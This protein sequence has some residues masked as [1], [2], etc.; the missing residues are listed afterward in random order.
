MPA[1]TPW[2]S[3]YSSTP[4]GF[5][6]T[7]PA[8]IALEMRHPRRVVTATLNGRREKILVLDKLL[9]LGPRTSDADLVEFHLMRV[10]LRDLPGW[11][12]TLPKGMPRPSDFNL[13]DA[14]LESVK[15][16][17]GP[18]RRLEFHLTFRNAPYRVALADLPA[19]LLKC[20]A[21]TV[22][23]A[24]GKKLVDIREMRLI[25]CE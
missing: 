7:N 2:S 15:Y 20:V 5:R 9:Y 23:D 6:I 14:R 22:K 21:A 13:M 10:R 16:L 11:P 4:D 18:R 25:T 24:V 19:S 12:P 8:L 17:P 3:F 1:R